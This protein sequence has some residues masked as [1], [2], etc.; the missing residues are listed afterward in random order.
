M[1]RPV[2][3]DGKMFGRGADPLREAHQHIAAR[4]AS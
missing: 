3:L 1:N 2:N 4:T